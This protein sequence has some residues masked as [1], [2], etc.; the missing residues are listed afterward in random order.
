MTMIAMQ[1]NK[2]FPMLIGD[3]L[4]SSQAQL[5]PDFTYPS[6]NIDIELPIA[7]NRHPFRMI[8]KTYIVHPQV[9]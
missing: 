4:F 5:N 1:E 8:Q 9:S 7:G 6:F 3:L 2:Q